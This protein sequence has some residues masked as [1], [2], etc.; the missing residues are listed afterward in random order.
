MVML[1]EV[2]AGR[3]AREQCALGDEP[4]LVGS[5]TPGTRLGTRLSGM[6]SDDPG[7]FLNHQWQ[8]F[9]E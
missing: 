1:T 9:G 3:A 7:D 8:P 5:P 2:K 4:R 6:L